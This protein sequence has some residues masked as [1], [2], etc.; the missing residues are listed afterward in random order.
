MEHLEPFKFW[1]QKVLPLVYDDSLSYYETLCKVAHK[2]NEDIAAIN[3]LSDNVNTLG[4]MVQGFDERITAV[5]ND[6]DAFDA[7]MTARFEQLTTE[8]NNE[9]NAK[10]AD[11]DAKMVEVDADIAAIDQ[12]VTSVENRLDAFIDEA[13][14][15]I[16]V[17]IRDAINQMTE[18]INRQLAFI[19]SYVDNETAALREWVYITLDEFLKTIGDVTNPLAYNI[20]TGV[21][22]DKLNNV[23]HD[24]Y[25]VMRPGALTAAEYDAM[26]VTAVERVTYMVGGEFRGLTAVEFDNYARRIFEKTRIKRP[27]T[28]HSKRHPYHGENVIYKDV[29]TLNTDLWRLAGHYTAEEFDLLGFDAATLDNLGYD[30]YRWD[31]DSADIAS[32]V[33]L[34][35]RCYNT[36]EIDDFGLSATY[37]D[38]LNISAYNFDNYSKRYLVIPD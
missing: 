38:D 25:T 21:D 15:E 26:K 37:R 12:R 27:G 8:I 31:W 23:I 19:R 14:E 9:V 24:L 35:V 5:E 13:R 28:I 11:V 20:I 4:E 18:I 2:L 33:P 34:N 6:F 3:T 36:E 16:E 17:A 10:L 7:R 29:V 22:R 32:V 1:C 30:A